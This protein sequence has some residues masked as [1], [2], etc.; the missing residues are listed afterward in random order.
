MAFTS[1]QIGVAV[2]GTGTVAT[3]LPAGSTAG[4]LLVACLFNTSGSA[5]TPPAGWVFAAG[6]TLSFTSV[7]YYPNNPGG[8]TTATF[9]STGN[10]RG[11]MSEFSTAAGTVQSVDNATL[12]SGSPPSTSFP[13]TASGST[14][15]GD[16]GIAAFEDV[17][18][19][20]TAGAT[21]TPPTGYTALRTIAN[22]LNTFS[23]SYKTGLAAGVQSVTASY[24]SSLHQGAWA[25]AL[26][27][28][29]E[30]AAS[31]LS[32]TTTS[33]MP[34][35]SVGLPYNQ[36]LTAAGGTPPYSWAIT[37]GSLPAGTSLATTG[38]RGGLSGI[39]V[40][41]GD[42]PS[43]TLV[44][45]AWETL[46]G[47]NCTG[48]KCYFQV[49]PDGSGIFPTTAADNTIQDCLN[50]NLV[51]YLCVKPALNPPTTHDYNGLQASVTAMQNLGLTVKVII[52]QEVEDQVASPV[53]YKAGL[54]FY[55]GAVHTPG[56]LLVHDSAGS[57][58]LLWSSFFP[59]G[60]S[61]AVVDE[62]MIDF[63]ANT[64]N[65]GTRIDPFMAMAAAT[66]K[67]VGVGEMGSSLGNSAVPPDTGPGSVTEYLNYVN[68]F[69]AALPPGLYAWYQQQNKNVNN[70]ITDPADF[71]I[72]LLQQIDATIAGGTVGGG[73]ITG[74][75]TAAA[76]SSFTAKAT[77]TNAV[78]ATAALS[79]TITGSA[80]PPVITT[81][82][83]PAATVGVAY[84][85]TALT[86]TGGTAPFAW[87]VT[88][89][90]VPDGL[91]LGPLGFIFGTPLADAATSPFTVTITDANNLTA[92]AALVITVVASL[93]PPPNPMTPR[94]GYPQVVIEA[95]L[96]AAAPQVPAGTFILDDPVY[97][98]LSEGNMLAD[99]TTW[100]DIAGLFINGSISRPSTRV[101]GPLI[102]YQGGTATGTFDNS[103]GNLDPDNPSSVYFGS[104]RPMVPF[105]VR[106]VYG[107]VSYPMWAGFT[108]SFAGADLTY[109]MG[110]DEVTITADDGFKVL[111][112]ITIPASGG[113]GGGVGDGD[114][115][116]SGARVTR[117]L[118]AAAWYT[119]HRRISVGDSPVQGTTW[120][121][122][123]LKLLQLTTD[124]EIGAL[125]MD[126]GGFVV[127]RNRQAILE[128]ARSAQVQ[129]VFGDL[130]GTIHGA[131]TE[132]ACI[133]HRRAT[134]DTTL[135]N[136]IQATSV[137]GTLQEA[138]SAASERTYLFP[139]T[140]AR[141]DLIL[142]DD[143]TT[144]EWAQWVLAVSLAGDDRFDAI[145]LDPVADPAGLF[146]QVLAREIGDRIQVYRRPQNS[147][148]T[149]VQDCFIR[150]I[151]HDL[152]AVAGTWSTTWTLQ[153]AL[154]YTGFLILDDPVFGLLN[155][156]KLAF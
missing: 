117:I 111:A 119:D 28:F 87:T 132:L 45:A 35:G 134:D 89:G 11:C 123:A 37:V 131:F 62:Y 52:W 68:G 91:T 39:T 24:S 9:T 14:A 6:G 64:Y 149:I 120:G 122:T 151:Q 118:D 98:Q 105:R 72:P 33:P 26:V 41:S 125:Y 22:Q 46:T 32:V 58:H 108:S 48:R 36:T 88:S 53:L 8:I 73:A 128:D 17:F 7:W 148:T 29:K 1:V 71:R 44:T 103:S 116:D 93:T 19:T 133:P 27:I 143:P 75:P 13:I 42:K 95:G 16:L 112:G 30:T 74:T 85:N 50:N 61:A 155:T 90:S 10:C 21:W 152:D 40:A 150:G 126:G 80:G 137:G 65:S 144:L 31:G 127:F 54:V 97:G 141:S 12:G 18:T 115:E 81:T 63:Y 100:T 86:E 23:A 107:S 49:N 70:I 82:S 135:A 51:L 47:I 56:A 104:L 130:P 145:T 139:R 94:A 101:Q 55:A 15:V 114:G 77:D 140:Y 146:P 147:G 84:P 34:G 99:S 153:S 3:T 5:F 96:T 59:S 60:A 69:A 113:G 38:G 83:L 66:G 110:Y 121:D 136:D 92:T 4:T 106:A 67:R 20:A 57:K 76:T 156:G 129:A 142:N 138:E 78:T 124:S 25:G 79:I 43:P 154:R 2:N 109:D 102:T